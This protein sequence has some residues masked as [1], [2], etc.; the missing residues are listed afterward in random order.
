[1]AK[2]A[3]DPRLHRV[4]E[5]RT[6]K[7]RYRP[8]PYKVQREAKSNDSPAGASATHSVGDEHPRTRLQTSNKAGSG[9]STGPTLHQP[10][11]SDSESKKRIAGSSSLQKG[12]HKRTRPG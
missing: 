2:E 7:P 10:Q 5:T 9:V 8:D 3:K 1:E 4:I 11:P 12:A 6:F